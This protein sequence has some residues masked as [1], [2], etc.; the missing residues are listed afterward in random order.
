MELGKQRHRQIDHLQTAGDHNGLPFEAR[1]PMAIRSMIPLNAFCHPFA[2]R[3][4]F[5]RNQGTVHLVR[6]GTIASYVPL[7]ESLIEFVEGPLITIPT[8]PVKQLSCSTI[9]GFPDPELARLFF[10]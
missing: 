7:L 8:F 1:K 5:L 4:A 3:Q 9:Q 6:I 2:H 10:K